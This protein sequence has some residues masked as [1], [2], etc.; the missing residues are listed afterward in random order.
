MTYAPTAIDL[1]RLPAPT[2]IDP[3]SFDV[4]LQGAIDR[5]V[6]DYAA[7]RALDPSL[8]AYSVEMLQTDPVII[9][10]RTWSNL[11]LYDRQRVND[12]FEA[13][14]AARARGSNLDAIVAGRNIE[15]QTIVAATPTSA[16]VMEGDASL[17]R[18]YL[19][20]FDM[21]AAG[22]AGRYLFDAYTAWP[23]S[24]D[25]TLGLWDA[26]VN[27]YAVHGRRGDTDVVIIGP[28]GRLP[29]A[30]ELATV[31]TAVTHPDR[32]PEAVAISVMAATRVE[33][34]VSLVLEVPGIGPAPSIVQA[35]AEARVRAAA[36]DR[37]L[38]GGELPAGLLAGAAYGA[39]VIAV[40]DLSPVVIAADPYKVPVMTGLTITTEVRA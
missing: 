20:S 19:L 2:A 9:E 18:R 37:I 30:E 27:G 23:Q 39:N 31:R 7:A 24:A 28:N 5:F 29:T 33:Y 40:R 32:A 34:T 36:T 6:A 13:L 4:L 12:V 3:L 26:R 21:P 22:S 10:L 1:S 11:R 16:A 15:R 8:P 38:I 25:R 14:L 17:L 35:E